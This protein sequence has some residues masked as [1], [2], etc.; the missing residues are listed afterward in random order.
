MYKMAVLSKIKPHSDAVDYFKELPFYNKPIKKPKVKRLK[1]IDR[2][3]E[4]PFYEQLSVIKKDQ[5][6]RGY[7]M[8]Y[9]DEIIERKNPI[10]QLEASES[11]I[12]DLFKY[13]INVKVLLKKYK[14]NG[15][16]EFSPVCFNSFTKTVIN[17]RFR[18]KIIFKKFYT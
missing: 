1:D 7:A 3:G 16:I 12:K 15:E 18:L 13:Q 11:S 6:F 2:L 17:H 4:L 9:K 5:A 14:L 10:V 8:S